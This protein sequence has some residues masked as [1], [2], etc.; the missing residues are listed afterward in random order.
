MNFF[1][2]FILS[3]LLNLCLINSTNNCINVISMSE[4]IDSNCTAKS[5]SEN[6]EG[7]LKKIGDNRSP[8]SYRCNYENAFCVR[9]VDCF[10]EEKTIQSSNKFKYKGERRLTRT[11]MMWMVRLQRAEGAVIK[12]GIVLIYL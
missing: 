5:D 12:R 11:G 6:M 9:N 1:N 3:G 8:I 10:E 4:I 7:K 2:V